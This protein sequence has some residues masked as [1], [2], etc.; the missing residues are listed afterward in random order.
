MSDFPISQDAVSP[1]GSPSGLQQVKWKEKQAAAAK[2][3]M[4]SR[5]S[6]D[7]ALTP[8]GK[9][10][11]LGT[12]VSGP[13][14]RS[15]HRGEVWP[16]PVEKNDYAKATDHTIRLDSGSCWFLGCPGP[17]A[18]SWAQKGFSATAARSRRSSRPKSSL[19][20]K[21]PISLAAQTETCKETSVEPQSG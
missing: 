7:V 4:K 8:G 11:F 18:C 13:R 12:C 5:A 16:D 9:A 20:T 1:V 17:V 2:E 21:T 15:L 3:K 6:A 19:R 14:F 10:L